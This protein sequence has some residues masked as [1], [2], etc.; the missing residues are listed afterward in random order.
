MQSVHT[1]QFCQMHIHTDMYQHLNTV[2]CLLHNIFSH[3]KADQ[4][5][6]TAHNI[7]MYIHYHI[8]ILA[9]M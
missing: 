5:Y 4:S 8:R 6:K 9:A 1:M 2:F 7:Y 3:L